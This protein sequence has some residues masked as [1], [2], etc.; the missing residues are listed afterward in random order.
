[1]LECKSTS[2]AF[3]HSYEIRALCKI[4]YAKCM[5]AE[6]LDNVEKKHWEFQN[7]C[8]NF[9]AD[10]QIKKV[11]KK[12]TIRKYRSCATMIHVCVIHSIGSH[13]NFSST[14]NNTTATGNK[15]DKFKSIQLLLKYLLIAVLVERSTLQTS[16]VN[17]IS[18]NMNGDSCTAAKK[19]IEQ[20]LPFYWI[21]IVHFWANSLVVRHERDNYS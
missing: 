7:N 11:T 12:E 6:R 16:K 2:I 17:S 4:P 20:W 13:S 14:I 1:M 10:E 9:E 21:E 8:I 15:N 3:N 19:E 18:M 5:Q